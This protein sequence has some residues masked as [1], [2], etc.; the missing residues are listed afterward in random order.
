MS[1]SGST[2][3]FVH[4]PKQQKEPMARSL[5]KLLN[6]DYLKIFIE[7]LFI[8]IGELEEWFHGAVV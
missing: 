3:T 2:F 5:K 1:L 4:P 6:N 7:C 8:R